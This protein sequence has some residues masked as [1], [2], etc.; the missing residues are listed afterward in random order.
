METWKPVVGHAKYEVSDTG[1][2]RKRSSENRYA[3]GY[4]LTPQDNG[5]GYLRIT[6]ALEVGKYKAFMVH[7]LV[8]ETFVGLIPSDREIN[9]KD[10]NKYNN[11][12]CNLELITRGGNIHHAYELGLR[13]R[14]SSFKGKHHTEETKRILSAQH[15][16]MSMSEEA[17]A[18]LSK[19]LTGR[20]LSIEHRQKLKKSAEERGLPVERI[21]LTTGEVKFYQVCKAVEA[22][23]FRPASVSD[24][25]K[26][27]RETYKGYGWQFAQRE[28]YESTV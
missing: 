20:T 27:K 15:T 4:C 5:R 1:Q 28:G 9:H 17:K 11:A 21:N 10:G 23:G 2:V 24:A 14:T 8:Y 25:C 16:G 18:K 26:E 3:A 12:T 19:S 22:D 6:L 7:R 13:D